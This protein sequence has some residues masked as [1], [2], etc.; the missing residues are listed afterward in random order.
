MV[1]AAE[2][3]AGAATAVGFHALT[4]ATFP[5]QILG[6]PTWTQARVSPRPVLSPGDALD[7][8]V[9]FNDYAYEEHRSE[10]R[11]GGFILH[12]PSVQPNEEGKGGIRWQSL[13]TSWPSARAR[14]GQQTW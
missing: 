1:T 10:V 6:G 7:V 5:S 9:A 13:S 14:A 3:L 11:E 4:F 12:D 8:L 2:M